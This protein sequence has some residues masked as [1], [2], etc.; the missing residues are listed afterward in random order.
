MLE[1]DIGP[2]NENGADSDSIAF[3][4]IDVVI[5]VPLAYIGIKKGQAIWKKQS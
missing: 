3:W 2:V 4:I 5:L 1:W